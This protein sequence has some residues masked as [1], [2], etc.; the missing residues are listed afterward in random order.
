MD[1]DVVPL[2]SRRR[3]GLPIVLLATGAV[4]LSGAPGFSA[5]ASSAR[6]GA[7]HSTPVTAEPVHV[8]H[9]PATRSAARSS[10]RKWTQSRLYYYE[11]IPSKWDWSLSKAVSKWNASGGRVKLVRT[12]SRTKAKVKIS[13]G[14]TGQAAGM[15]TIG[16][17]AGAFVR[18][19]PTYASVDSTN[20]YRRIEVMAIFAH[21]LGHVLGFGHTTTACSLMRSVLD[22]SA[23]HLPD[24]TP[25]GYHKCRTIDST[26]VR[27]FVQMYGGR[28]HFPPNT[29]CLIDPMP[30][31]LASLT[32]TGGVDSPVTAL[33]SRPAT[34]PTGS[35]VEIRMW[36]AVACNAAPSWAETILVSPTALQW[37]DDASRTKSDHCFQARL[38]NRFGAGK[39]AV[40]RLMARWM[41]PPAAP[42]VHTQQWNQAAGELTF[43]EDHPEGT[44][45]KAQWDVENPNQCPEAYTPGGPGDL[46]VAGEDG[47]RS[48]QVPAGT[49]CVSFFTWDAATDSYSSAT[50]ESVPVG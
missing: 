25:A 36:P 22:V 37:R 34:V 3:L 7:T 33:W 15:A 12:T 35:K 31:A 26:L 50:K 10:V 24:S 5:G 11:T 28:A 27:R 45:L 2:L 38:V 17:A 30:S 1:Y 32:F 46:Y 29:W 48:M 23:C 9:A 21:E 6:S 43:T 8:D 16:R 14:S 49:A 18:L 44:Y 4:L 13:Y 47:S 19:S 39:A 40:P 20:A 41:Q 42:V